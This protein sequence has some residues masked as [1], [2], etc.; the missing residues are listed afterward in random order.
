[1]FVSRDVFG[2][3]N[4]DKLYKINSLKFDYWL[5]GPGGRPL[6]RGIAHAWAELSLDKPLNGGNMDGCNVIAVSLRAEEV[7]EVTGRSGTRKVA[8][9]S[10]TTRAAHQNGEWNQVEIACSQRA[11]TVLINGEEI[12]HLEVPGPVT[13]RIAFSFGGA[14]LHLANVRCR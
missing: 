4:T 6:P 2:I 12:N 14:E 13:A 1:M 10:A 7:G 3:L 11:I 5:T 9:Q 8:T